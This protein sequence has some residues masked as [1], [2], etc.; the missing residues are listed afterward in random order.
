[1]SNCQPKVRL[2]MFQHR[3]E[4]STL[5]SVRW[6]LDKA[7][8]L[9]KQRFSTWR[10][11]TCVTKCQFSLELSLTFCNRRRCPQWGG[12]TWPSW[13]G[14]TPWR[15]GPCQTAPSSSCPE[16]LVW[17]GLGK[18]ND[19]AVKVATS[20]FIWIKILFPTF[21]KPQGIHHGAAGSGNT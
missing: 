17:S 2:E 10:L 12:T 3:T 19:R 16:N 8:M 9:A 11:K 21:I 15:R 4:L 6:H 5:T 13:W 18:I 14:G 7:K 1:M 20:F